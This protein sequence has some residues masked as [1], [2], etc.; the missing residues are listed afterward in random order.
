[1]AKKALEP[2][3]EIKALCQELQVYGF[4]VAKR[5]AEL[6]GLYTGTMPCPMCK[7]NLR[8]VRSPSNGHFHAH[9]ETAN[10][11]RISE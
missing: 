6:R 8:F 9:C 4:A 11:I 1:V 3:A 7:Q 2:E 10:C 5:I